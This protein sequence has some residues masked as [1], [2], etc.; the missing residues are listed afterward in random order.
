[1]IPK[2]R[3]L[4][5]ETPQTQIWKADKTNVKQWV[6]YIFISDE[7]VDS[8]Q[9]RANSKFSVSAEQQINGT[10]PKTRRRTYSLNEET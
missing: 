7:T 10:D 3:L 2:I 6:K 4:T 9:K 5:P 8:K 1:M